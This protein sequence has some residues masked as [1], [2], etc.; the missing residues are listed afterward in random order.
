MST[1]MVIGIH[2]IEW[3][4]GKGWGKAVS[5]RESICLNLKAQSFIVSMG[6]PNLEVLMVNDPGF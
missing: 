4:M 6:P 2:A 1:L 3:Q 5:I